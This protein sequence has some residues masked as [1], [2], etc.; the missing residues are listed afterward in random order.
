MRC[1]AVA[2]LVVLLPGL[3]SA[4]SPLDKPAFTATPAELLAEAKKVAAGDSGAVVLREDDEITFDDKGLGMHRTRYVVAITAQSGEDAWETLWQEWRPWQQDVPK[5]RARVISPSGQVAE[6][7]PDKVVQEPNRVGALEHLR[8]PLPSLAVG[9]VIEEEMTTA[10]RS[11]FPGGRSSGVILGSNDPITSQRLVVSAPTALKVHIVERGLPAGTKPRHV[12][13]AGRETW[14]YAFEHVAP[15]RHEHHAPDDQYTFGTITATTPQSWSDVAHAYSAAVTPALSFP[16][17]A[18]LPHGDT[19]EVARA[20]NA[21]LHAHVQ[22]SGEELGDQPYDGVHLDTIVKRGSAGTNELAA[23]LVTLLRGAGI[24]A[25]FALVDRAPGNV[26]DPQRPFL[27]SFSHVLVRAKIAGRDVWIDPE[28][29]DLRVGQLRAEDQGRRAL[30]IADGTLLHT[31]AAPPSENHVREV[32]TYDLAQLGEGRVTETSREGGVFEAWPRTWIRDKSPSETRKQFSSYVDGTYHGELE[33]YSTTPIDDLDKP[34]ELTITANHVRRADT[35]W[36][37]IDVW[38]YASDAFVHV[39]DELMDHDAADRTFDLQILEPHTCEIENRLVIPD[40]FTVPTVHPDRTRMLGALRLIEHQQ[41]DGRTFIVSF[42]LDAEK[43]RLTPAEVTETRRAINDLR[44]ESTHIVIDQTGWALVEAGEFAKGLADEDRLIAAAPRDAIRHARLAQLLLHVGDGDGARREAR[45][46]VELDPKNVETQLT[47]GWVL[48]FDLIGRRWAPGFDRAGALAALVKA[49]A[50]DP[51][52]VGALTELANVLERDA[53]GHRYEPGSDLKGAEAA[54]R[55]VA[56]RDPSDEHYRNLARASLW[57]GDY[58]NALAAARKLS[59]SKERDGLVTTG[60]AL[61]EGADAATRDAEG[62]QMASLQ[63][64][65]AATMLVRQYDLSRKLFAAAGGP[66][67]PALSPEALAHVHR[68]DTPFRPTTDPKDVEIELMLEEI[69]PDRPIAVAW[70]KKVED[71]IREERRYALLAR[72]ELVTMPMMYD[73]VR[74]TSN[75]KV[76]GDAGAWRIEVSAYNGM[77]AVDYLASDGKFPRVIGSPLHLRGVGE[78]VLRLVGKDDAAAARLLDWVLKDAP[79]SRIRMVWGQNVS[80]DTKAIELAGAALARD[81]DRSLAIAT[82][83]LV[84]TTQ[85]QLVCDELVADAYIAKKRWADL[86]TFAGG[87]WASRAP[88]SPAPGIG[89]ATAL[90][91]LGRLEEAQ[92][93]LDDLLAKYPGDR[94][95]ISMRAEVDLG[96]RHAEDAVHRLGEIVQ[97]TDATAHELNNTAW[98]QVVNKIDLPGAVELAKRAVKLDAKAPFIA[99]TLA[100]AE[101]ESDD[102]RAALR[103]IRKAADLEPT[104]EVGSGDWYIVGL[105]LEKAGRRDSAIAAYRRVKKHREEL[106]TPE[107]YTLAAARLKALGATK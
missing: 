26:A 1:T 86:E 65:A 24:A 33:G 17:P 80:R 18:D 62:D 82:K 9:S 3:A 104:A 75:A 30:S 7:A 36:S 57:A 13:N 63:T 8:A 97:R 64:A 49:R 89:R 77:T 76:E 93:V 95:V 67:N 38:L 102:V 71:D 5:V 20:V 23:L 59:A 61:T 43:T 81:P 88:K 58:A 106:F 48:T 73:F 29:R 60:I 98:L 55:T 41:V 2:L 74:A 4:G 78:Q 83:C 31:P 28:D 12:S 53:R 47:L 35:E 37:K 56:E 32:R 22:F 6:L 69:D 52:H 87:L 39:D 46:A 90:I 51:E 11:K 105:I 94:Y 70:D 96:E 14:S 21:W 44:N 68:D 99:N 34:F 92:Q 27:G 15:W 42:R 40:G 10:D 66:A 85:L 45:K 107:P 84:T 101:V 16:Q 91:Q 100:G 72:T 54:W 25:D 50:L 19:V 79:R 103:D